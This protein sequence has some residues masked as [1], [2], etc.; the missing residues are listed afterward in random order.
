EEID[1]RA[2]DYFDILLSATVLK[3]TAQNIQPITSYLSSATP[4]SLAPNTTST[5]ALSDA[6]ALIQSAEENREKNIEGIIEGIMEGNT[7]R[8]MEENRERIMKRI[9]EENTE[10]N[11]EENRERII[12]G[13]TEENIEENAG[14]SIEKNIAN[15]KARMKL[16]IEELD[17]LLKKD[18]GYI[19]KGTKLK[20]RRLP[21]NNRGKFIKVVSLIDDERISL[22][23]MSYLRSHK[24]S[25]NPKVL[26]EFVENE[27]FLSLGIKK[28]TTISERT[29]STWLNKLE[30][31]YK[32]WKKEPLLIEYDENDLNKLVEKNIPPNEILHCVI[33]HDET[34]LAANDD[35]KTG[36]APESEQKLRPKRQGRCIHISEFLCEPLG[37]VHLTTEQHLSYPEIPNR[38]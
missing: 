34:T 37:R 15:E 14:E 20:W 30:W 33:T 32:E 29:V 16:A 28:K 26:K 17:N 21:K 31:H 36:W 23:I 12:E 4:H 7:E 10:E 35:K 11:T 6:V 27:V 13:N 22:K 8:N 25:V 9:V 5:C 38:Y 24:F 1:E 18:D 2:A 19:D 3:K